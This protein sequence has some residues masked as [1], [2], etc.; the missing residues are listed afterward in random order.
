M[1][2]SE[3]ERLPLAFHGRRVNCCRANAP[4][5][6]AKRKIEA[7][8]AKYPRILDLVAAAGGVGPILAQ[9]RERLEGGEPVKALHLL[10]VTESAE[11]GNP[12]MLALKIRT[13]EELR[14]RARLQHRNFYEISWLDARLAET[15]ASVPTSSR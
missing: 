3:D 11:P 14:R 12:E 6:V 2:G 8:D 7:Q 4:L 13:F 5:A 1:L 15:K 10:E 9:A